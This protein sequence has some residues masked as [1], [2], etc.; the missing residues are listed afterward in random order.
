MYMLSG[1]SVL[2]D[3]NF[4]RFNPDNEIETLDMFKGCISLNGLTISNLNINN[5][6]E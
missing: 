6:R 1:C 4:P 2:Q 5:N 3:I